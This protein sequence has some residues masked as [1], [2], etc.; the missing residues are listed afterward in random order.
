[1]YKYIKDIYRHTGIT[2]VILYCVGGLSV[3]SYIDRHGNNKLYCKIVVWNPI[4]W[5]V[6]I[7]VFAVNWVFETI[8]LFLS[9]IKEIVEANKENFG[10]GVFICSIKNNI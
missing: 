5:V 3:K 2:F 4:L 6:F 7:L 9:G 10:K 1:M 8:R